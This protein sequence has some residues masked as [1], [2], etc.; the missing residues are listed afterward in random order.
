LLAVVE[1]AVTMAVEAQVVTE[2]MSLEQPLAVA[3][4]LKESFLLQQVL[5]TQLQLARVALLAQRQH[6]EQG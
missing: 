5:P 6:L 4:V 3:L 1:V 2:Q